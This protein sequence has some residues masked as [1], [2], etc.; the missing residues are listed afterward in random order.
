LENVFLFNLYRETMRLLEDARDY[1]RHW[2][3]QDRAALPLDQG[4]AMSR[5][6]LSMTAR[7]TSVMAWVM[8]QRAVH[9]G[10][11]SAEEA[12][13]PDNRLLAQS[14]HTDPVITPRDQVPSRL[15][16][17]LDSSYRLYQRVRRMESGAWLN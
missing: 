7:L 2:E 1:H 6:C 17:L 8:T 5:E 14:I 9:A 15:W 11:I 16:R 4:C 3:R 12:A 13:N 10:E